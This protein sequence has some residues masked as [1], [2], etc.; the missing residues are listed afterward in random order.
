[1]NF[2]LMLHPCAI[3]SGHSPRS[4]SRCIFAGKQDVGND[5]STRGHR[6]AKWQ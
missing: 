5:V 6:H 3:H 2:P 4:G 1:M